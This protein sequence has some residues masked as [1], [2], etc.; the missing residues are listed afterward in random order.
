MVTQPKEV[1]KWMENK[2][3]DA[4]KEFTNH[5][6]QKNVT[7]E[8]HIRYHDEPIWLLRLR[9]G[10]I[11]KRIQ[12]SVF[13]DEKENLKIYVIPDKSD[14]SPEERGKWREYNKESVEIPIPEKDFKKEKLVFALKKVKRN[15]IE[16]S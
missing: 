4:I 15:L 11:V 2:I 10:E 13:D 3:I 9:E 1:S 12:I 8:I 14:I 16:E 6:S 5:D 7:W